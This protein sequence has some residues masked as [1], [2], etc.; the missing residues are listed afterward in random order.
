M[1]GLRGLCWGSL[2]VSSHCILGSHCFQEAYAVI[3]SSQLWQLFILGG[4]DWACSM[5]SSKELKEHW[6]HAHK[7]KKRGQK[8][9]LLQSWQF[10]CWNKTVTV[11]DLKCSILGLFPWPE[12]EFS[13]APQRGKSN[14]VRERI[15]F[16]K[17]SI[18]SMCSLD[19]LVTL[20]YFKL[21]YILF[22][23]GG[24]LLSSVL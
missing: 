11:Y 21:K 2:K 22:G 23:W 3:L 14:S 5:L 7:M 16:I 13:V 1:D 15:Y 8:Q 12:A 9:C 20:A 6:L 24:L 19:K 10:S 4:K 17:N 18:I